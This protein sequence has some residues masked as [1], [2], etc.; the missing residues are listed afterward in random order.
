M[1]KN[2]TF[3]NSDIEMVKY[4]PYQDQIIDEIDI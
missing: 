1:F 4:E 3:S 2:S